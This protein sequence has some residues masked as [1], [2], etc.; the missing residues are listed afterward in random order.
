[1]LPT[2]ISFEY[3]GHEQVSVKCLVMLCLCLVN[4]CLR[5]SNGLSLGV[6]DESQMDLDLDPFSVLILYIL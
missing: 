6:V 4:S 2:M 1:M 3:L 5:T